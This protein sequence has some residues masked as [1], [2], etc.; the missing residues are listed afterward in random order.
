MSNEGREKAN[1]SNHDTS[2][3]G[4]NR[5]SLCPIAGPS[6]ENDKIPITSPRPHPIK[7]LASKVGILGQR[8]MIPNVCDSGLEPVARQTGDS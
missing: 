6:S 2:P 7:F 4:R 5:M 8:L 3:L 1:A